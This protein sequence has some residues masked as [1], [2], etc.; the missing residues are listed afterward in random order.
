MADAVMTA[1]REETTDAPLRR[2][3]AARRLRFV[4]WSVDWADVVRGLVLSGLAVCAAVL[5]GHAVTGLTLPVESD[6]GL[7]AQLPVTYWVGVV[8]LN[9]VFVAAL[10][11]G[12]R[13]CRVPSTKVMVVLLG[14]LLVTLYGVA[15]L[16]TDYPRGE[17]AWRH[18]GIADA[19]QRTGTINPEVDAYFNWP[20]FFAL[21]GL[22]AESTGVDPLTLAVWA[23]VANVA[24][25]LLP[26]AAIVRTLTTDTRRLWLT[27][28]VFCLG[29]WQ[30]QDY[31]SPQAFAF[32]LYLVVI[33][34]LLKTLAATAPV[35][36]FASGRNLA[37]LR[38]WWVSRRPASPDPAKRVG[39]LLACLLLVAVISASHQLTPF[40]L[41]V[42]L[43]ALTVSGRVWAPGLLLLALVVL[44]I[45]L[46]Y[47]ASSYLLGHPPLADIGLGQSATAN[48]AERVAGTPGHLLV[49]RIRMGLAALLWLVA[50][51]GVLRDRR[52]G[53]LDI[54]PVLLMG[55][56]FILLPAQSYGGEMLI[57]VS[58]FALPF[59]AYLAG[60]ALLPRRDRVN[61]RS[62]LVLAV[63]CAAIGALMVTGR[64]GNTKFDMFTQHEIVAAQELYRLAPED[65]AIISGAHPTPW[66]NQEYV[67]HKYRTVKDLCSANHEPNA[68]GEAVYAYA[69]HNPG[70]A[71]LLMNRASQMSMVLQGVI[72]PG[73]YQ[74]F[75]QWLGHVP[76]IHL[77][78]ENPDARIYRI[79]PP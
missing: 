25:W 2:P 38:T 57:R 26:L 61:R 45:W 18:I 17:V 41:V 52:A 47:P 28:W 69:R 49:V 16:S 1:A 6:V 68:C 78:Y 42:A 40:M 22:F 73:T 46:A 19:L 43:F 59:T 9:L 8:V 51:V 50:V 15:A 76:T 5:S 54:R 21:L 44:G 62:T 66:R 33:C 30:D 3:S 4:L 10:L 75:E 27:L 48:V 56:P 60:G 12:G 58:L 79:D 64:Y 32:F 37:S 29:N 74:E 34:L 71:M 70:G 39:A 63:V 14:A 11:G 67:E 7:V 55:A 77:V 23:P 72:T 65:S 31:L 35:R 53:R 36:P 24:L 20:G 13:H